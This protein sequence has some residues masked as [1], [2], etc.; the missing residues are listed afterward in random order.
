M[1]IKISKSGPRWPSILNR[2]VHEVASA[3]TDQHPRP[4]LRKYH[5]MQVQMW[6]GRVHVDDID[7]WVE[8]VR[9]KH[10]LAHW[11]YRR[12]SSARP[13]TDDIYEIMIDAD[14]KEKSESERPFNIE[15]LAASIA[16]NGIQDSVVLF[17]DSASKG[18]LWDGNRRFYATKHI[19]RSQ[20]FKAAQGSAK[21]IPALVYLPSGDP[22]HDEKVHKAILTE[23]NFKEKD[24]IPWP[25][26]VKAAEIHSVYQKLVQED[27]A[28]STL[29]REAK[30]Q[31]AEEYGLKGWRVADR[32][33]KMYGL[34][35]DFK[36][37][38]EEEKEEEE[39][40]VELKIQ[41]KFEYFDELTKPA[42]WGSLKEDPVARDEVFCWLWDGKFKSFADVRSVPKILTDPVARIQANQNDAGAV[43]RAIDTIVVNDPT[44]AKDKTAA[45][46][47]V[48]QFADWLSSFR[49]EDFRSLEEETLVRFQDMLET[50][51]AMLEGLHARS[52]PASPA[53]H[54]SH[55]GG[56][57]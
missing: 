48:K 15:R 30:V 39:T 50:V 49:P 44:R 10:Y 40:E 8:N 22:A 1:A 4:I 56:A 47:K 18:T 52:R 27:P 23:Q 20:Q 24:H 33:V 55:V 32:W 35:M 19:M 53:G 51:T 41:E 21:W 42:V 29:R 7:G 28:D 54:K 38:F 14:R 43:K 13:S 57:A 11:K 45:D 5:G 3:D 25:S 9:L 36:E 34:A 26:Y 17:I 6:S 37:F 16:S 2:F 46:A 12:G 31:I